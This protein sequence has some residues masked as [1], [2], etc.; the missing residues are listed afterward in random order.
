MPPKRMFISFDYDHDEV[1]KNLFVGQAKHPDTPFSLSDWSVKEPFTGNWKD[2]VR[3]RIRKVEV[4]VVICGKNMGTATGVDVEIKIAQEEKV[5]YF[6]LCGY[7]DDQY[8][9]PAAALATDKVYKW[10]W[11]NV[12]NLI[13]GAR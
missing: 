5:P 2:K 4:M 13:N 8:T 12:K 9:K 1:L 3:D 11:E 6:L 10:S 7:S